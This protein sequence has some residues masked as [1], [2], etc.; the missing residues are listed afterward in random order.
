MLDD[1]I[2]K[3]DLNDSKYMEI[4]RAM[5]DKY[6]VIYYVNV[7]TNEYEEYCASMEY[8]RL[9]ISTMGKDFFAEAQEN[10]KR[11][12]YR[13]DYPM[14]ASAMEKEMVLKG[15]EE[16][17]KYYL[18]YRL[19]LDGRPQYVTLSA[20]RADEVSDYVIFAVTNVDAEK[21]R[22]KDYKGKL[23]DAIEL[24]NL[25]PITEGSN[26][27]A[28][29]QREMEIDNEIS[30][31]TR[32]PF[33]ILLCDI[34]ELK[35]INDSYGHSTGDDFIKMAYRS[36]SDIFKNSSVYRYGGDEFVAILEDED[37]ENRDKLCEQF[38]L[39]QKNNIKEG[40]ATVSYGLSEY[41]PATDIRLQDVFERAD[42]KMYL[43]KKDVGAETEDY[44]VNYGNTPGKMQLVNNETV[45]F[46]RLFS[47]L[48]SA[49][50]NFENPDVAL[51]ENALIDI[52]TL[53]RLSKAYT[54]VYRNP[55]EEQAG[56]GEV[57]CCYDTGKEGVEVMDYRVV[58][59]VQTIVHMHILMEP[60]ERPLTETEKWRVDLT[61][62]ATVSFI[63]RNR[64][65]SRVEELTFFDD[66]GY[67]NLRSYYNYIM[68]ENKRNNLARKVAIRYNLRHFTLVNQ[69]LG[70]VIGDLVIK[71]HFKNLESLIGDEGIVCRLGGDNFVAI[72]G[73]RQIGQVLNYLTETIVEYEPEE[74]KCVSVSTSAGVF[75]IPKGYVINHPG[76]IMGNI[77]TAFQT[78]QNGGKEK[79]VF[80]DTS[81]LKD[82]EKSMKVQQLFPE[83]LRKEEFV[84]YYQ[85]KVNIKT[86]ELI[87]AEALCRWIHNG[88]F[89][90]PDKFI[91]MLEETDDICK[92]DFYVLD[93]VCRDIHRWIQEGKHIVRVS[94]NLSR[95][96]MIN[97]NLL[98]SMLKIIDRHEIPHSCIEVEL[99]ETTTDV[100]FND[101][102]RVVSGLQRYGI[103]TAVDDFGV[104][105][106]SLNLLRELPWNVIKIDRSFL[107][108]EEDKDISARRIMFKYVVAMAKELGMECIVE[109]VETEE[110]LKML[111][112]NDCDF[113]QGFL[114]DRPLPMREF[115]NRLEK[116]FYN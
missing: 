15:I 74:G 34:N 103:Y 27:R 96:H 111:S 97:R 54:Y 105:Y 106:S 4:A 46:Y 75:R 5:A 52:S 67:R 3:E 47:R 108:V 11:D 31:K 1:R 77:I 8:A 29:V 58:S 49:M 112:E 24:A 109:G 12:I 68:R 64:L 73:E 59:S 95:K 90:T 53:F 18:N 38:N 19:I 25:D 110:Q 35:K 50:T 48:I 102:K 93:H 14:M 114:Y 84:V 70:R 61:M 56:D 33:A 92:L 107:P 17:G 65:K 76:D 30:E 88:E 99:T 32:K 22:E 62:R 82:K 13:D 63:S 81:L 36:I 40:K 16:T 60:G 55:D 28:Y 20:V 86:G 79:I 116:K 9:K 37:Y 6:E 10:M 80:Y 115:E 42:K 7:V 91:P 39:I 104:G 43:H 71:T 98:Q 51:I 78:A 26:K 89:I 94:V 87:G 41:D 2:E 23:N 21:R 66:S 45:E 44:K 83:A 72:C 101:L 85:P 100:Q 57:L 113:A 69:E